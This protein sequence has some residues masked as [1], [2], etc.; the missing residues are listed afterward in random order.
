VV[1][2]SA[3]I[4]AATL[5]AAGVGGHDTTGLTWP[6]VFIL[7]SV[8]VPALGGALSGIGAQ[9]EYARHAERSEH[10]IEYLTE[11]R[12]DVVAADG[13]DEVRESTREIA[14][15][16]LAENRDWFGVLSFRDLEPHS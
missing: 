5:H 3:T 8:A 11:A 13:I 10:M 6:S 12:A 4:V 1:L 2:L 15:L 7:I 16:F 14:E 9:R